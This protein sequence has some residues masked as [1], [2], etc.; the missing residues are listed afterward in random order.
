M[1]NSAKPFDR[2]LHVEF[3][4]ALCS[5][6]SLLLFSQQQAISLNYVDSACSCITLGRGE[7]CD[8]AW[9]Q[10]LCGEAAIGEDSKRTRNVYLS[11]LVLEMQEG[12]LMP[13]FLE[14]PPEG[15]LPLA[16][17]VF[18]PESSSVKEPPWLH[19]IAEGT[20]AD[21]IHSSKD[22]R[23]YLASRY[24]NDGKG[25]FSYMA[26]SV[27]DQEPLFVP[28]SEGGEVISQAS[29]GGSQSSFRTKSQESLTKKPTRVSITQLPFTYEQTQRGCP[30]QDYGGEERAV[31]GVGNPS[32]DVSAILPGRVEERA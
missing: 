32:P 24:L 19:A 2:L 17:D 1:F 21:F 22:G 12:R 15:K 11:H 20:G 13:P 10:K 3:L 8:G 29:D 18:G 28:L 23:T 31:S 7:Q 26:I 5:S 9:L 4:I 25:A 30:T 6:S 16:V 14:Y 27:A